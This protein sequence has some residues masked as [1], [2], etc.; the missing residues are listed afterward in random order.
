MCL[1]LSTKEASADERKSFHILLRCLSSVKL[2]IWRKSYE[3]YLFAILKAKLKVIVCTAELRC[4]KH[5]SQE[6]AVEYH[7][8]FFLI[9]QKLGKCY[10]QNW[11]NITGKQM[12][13]TQNLALAGNLDV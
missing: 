12:K 2:F 8:T 1:N 10:K 7:S 11:K 5:I 13:I 9:Y 3:F 4:R 6:T